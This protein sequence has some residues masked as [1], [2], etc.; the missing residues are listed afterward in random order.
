MEFF[1]M[2]EISIY[3]FVFIYQINIAM[4]LELKNN[5]TN[6]HISKVLKFI[7]NIMKRKLFKLLQ[8]VKFKNKPVT[9]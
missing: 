1:L 4:T 2:H 5:P 7:V 8:N 3:A 6:H 9:Q